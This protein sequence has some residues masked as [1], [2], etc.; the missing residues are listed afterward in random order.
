MANR[1][2]S[3]MDWVYDNEYEKVNDLENFKSKEIIE[4]IRN[5]NFKNSVFVKYLGKAKIWKSSTT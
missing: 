2:K 4:K 1:K 3:I 5:E